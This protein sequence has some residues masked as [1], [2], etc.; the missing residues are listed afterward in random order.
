[1]AAVTRRAWLAALGTPALS[2]ASALDMAWRR[3]GFEPEEI[4]LRLDG[5]LTAGPLPE[6]V[7]LWEPVPP[8]SLLKPFVA[9]AYAGGHGFRYP[10]VECTGKG[11]WLAAG[12][13]ELGIADALAQSC[14]V[15]FR[16]LARELNPEAFAWTAVRLGLPAPPPEAKPDSYWGL[17]GEWLVPPDRLLH[18]YAELARRRAEPGLAPVVE[19][20]RRAASEGTA[21][22]LGMAALAKTGTSRC[23]HRGSNGDGYACVLY[24]ADKPRYTM[25]L[26]LHGRTGRE[27]ARAAGVVFET[28][29]RGMR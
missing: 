10:A 17:G 3:A 15:Y 24:P 21:K 2:R 6:W 25:L 16:A 8:G 22:G 28:F 14:N 5:P 20:L 12:H 18:A 1:V 9:A 19:G 29:L 26:Q 7:S 27:A 11:C 23:V 13:G 4:R